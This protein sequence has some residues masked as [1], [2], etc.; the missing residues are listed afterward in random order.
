MLLDVLV[1]VFL[2][3]CL[4]ISCVAVSSGHGMGRRHR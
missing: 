3:L 2:L 1:A 4:G